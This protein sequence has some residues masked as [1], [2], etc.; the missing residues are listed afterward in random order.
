M[1]TPKYFIC[2]MSKNIVDSVIKLRSPLFGLLPSPRQIDFDGGYVNSWKTKTF[3]EYVI[4]RSN[5][6]IQ[7]DHSGP[8]QGSTNLYE[9]LD[10][11]LKFLDI[12]HLDV[13]KI[14]EPTMKKCAEETIK[15]VNYIDSIN[16]NI[17]FEVGTEESIFKYDNLE[18]SNFLYKLRLEL[19]KHQ[20]NN[21][22]YVCIQSGVKLDLINR[23]NTGI[24]NLE[25]LRLMVEVCKNFGKKSK[26]HNG[27]YLSK[28]DIKIRFDNGLDTLN[29]G[30]EIAQ[31]ETETYLENM[32]QSQIDKF[33]EICVESKKWR[34]WVND[35]FDI[36]DKKKLI[37][38]CGHYNFGKLPIMNAQREV[39]ER[40]KNKLIELISYV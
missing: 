25:K 28:D 9:S 20:F 10:E 38:I 22:E 17:K 39:K 1:N 33:Y 4:N 7:R 6:I 8:N 18:L 15:Y 32:T 24:F 31:I 16:S 27:D 34:K 29:I 30:P 35:D 37:M 26:E 3:K 40:I 12:I 23:R 13:F 2:P 21:I 36:T 5:I 19:Y 14:L 11:D